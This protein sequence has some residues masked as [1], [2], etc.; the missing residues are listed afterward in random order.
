MPTV[1]GP[2]SGRSE[3]L[4]R[5]SHHFPISGGIASRRHA[6]K[7][8]GFPKLC[9]PALCRPSSRGRKGAKVR[10]AQPSTWSP[11]SF[12]YPRAERRRQAGHGV[13]ES[14]ETDVPCDLTVDLPDLAC[15]FMTCPR[16]DHSTVDV[17]HSKSTLASRNLPKEAVSRALPATM[18]GMVVAAP[19]WMDTWAPV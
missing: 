18:P 10:F 2:R 17:V 13:P 4:R 11:P 6:N 12:N 9:S 16:A 7:L 1:A 3:S 19:A 5:S 8:H 14:E 15:R